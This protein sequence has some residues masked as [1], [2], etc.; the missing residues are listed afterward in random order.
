MR[1]AANVASRVEES[2]IQG[3]GGETFNETR[4]LQVEATLRDE[5]CSLSLSRLSS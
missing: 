1:W 2:H 5:L 4:K 3:F